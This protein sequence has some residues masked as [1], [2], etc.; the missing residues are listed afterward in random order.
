MTMKALVKNLGDKF[1]IPP[2]ELANFNFDQFADNAMKV[3]A[4][5]MKTLRVGSLK[6]ETET[7]KVTFSRKRKK[8]LKPKLSVIQ[9]SE[10]VWTLILLASW[11]TVEIAELLVYCF[12][13]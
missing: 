11:M 8:K 6:N 9:T 10:A 1:N 12:V 2:E 13:C 7:W 5:E 4:G 3:Q